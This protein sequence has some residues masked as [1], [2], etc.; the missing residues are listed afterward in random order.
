MKAE[1]MIAC[2]RARSLEF[3]F[4]LQQCFRSLQVHLAQYQKTRTST[5][6]AGLSTMTGGTLLDH[7]TPIMQKAV[8]QQVKST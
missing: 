4:D 7:D 3:L 2:A 5:L 8:I 1:F 6:G